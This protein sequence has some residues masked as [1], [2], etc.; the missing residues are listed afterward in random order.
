MSNKLKVL[1]I[2]DHPL[3]S[4]G[5]GS[6]TRYIIEGLL[7]T[8]KF[9]F[10]SLGGALKHKEYNPQ[11]LETWGD[12]WTIF[13]I[14][15]YGDENIVR[16]ILDIEKPDAVWFMTD[17][18]FFQWL[19]NMSDEIRDRG[20]PLL[21]YH[22]WDNY[23]VPK[24]NQGAYRSCDFIGCISKL[25]H[26]IVCQLGMEEHSAYIPHAVN[27]DVFKPYSEKK[28][29][30]KR[31]KMIKP[32]KDK[33]IIFYNSRNARRKMTSDIVKM[34]K[35]LL[36]KVGQDKAFLLM[37]TDPHDKEGANL[38]EVANLLGLKNTQLGF[39]A[40]RIPPEAMADYYNIADV[41]INISN[42]EG[43][44]LSCLE[45]LSCGTPVIINKTGG[46]QDQ[47]VD[48]EGNVFGVVI[49][50]A[51]RTL[52]GSQQ[53]PYIFDDRCS[54]EDVLDALLH[55]YKMSKKKRREIGKQAREW[56]LKAFSMKQMVGKWEEALTKY[57]ETYK[58]HGYP[59]RIRFS[60]V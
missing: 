2:S 30:E 47:P 9:K 10:V 60:R 15:G 51:T 6:Q 52:T 45:S 23:P 26:D 18:R 20:I 14:N 54:D 32:H 29:L 5:V 53:I 24:F 17:P 7:A 27:A 12:D 8:G 37:H 43:F 16:E 19:F 25:T 34:F 42:N 50:P 38:I 31:Q 33:F 46:L 35:K 4:S 59:D 11:R 58:K 13:P 44:G 1:T 48:D 57:I 56:A 36:D 41:T 28:I 22:V 21:Y 39:S 40:M 49:E 3:V 55:I